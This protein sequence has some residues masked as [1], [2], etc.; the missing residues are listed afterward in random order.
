M[1]LIIEQWRKFLIE[2]TQK[3]GELAKDLEDTGREGK[4]VDVR[5]MTHTPEMHRSAMK[6]VMAQGRDLKK[7]FAKN[8]DREFLDS[9]VTIHWTDKQ[10]MINM[11]L[12]KLNSRDELS[13]AAYLPEAG[14]QG[15]EGA[16]NDFGIVIKGHITLLANDMDQIYTGHGSDYTKADPQRTKMSGANKGAQQVYNPKE[17]EK[18]EVLVLDQED[19]KPHKSFRGSNANEALVDN[20]SPVA[21]IVPGHREEDEWE[22][23]MG[24]NTPK[25][26]PISAHGGKDVNW[27]AKFEGLVKKAGL[28]IPVMSSG[29]FKRQWN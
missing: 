19:W 11:L 16:F 21:L 9:L 1:K 20:W 24:K 17:Y 2:D 29:E 28:D 14:V 6:D 18:Y 22:P 26:S 10:S 4:F 23:E 15:G 7:A 13:A 12:G 27:V 3:R 25:P 8:A 5:R